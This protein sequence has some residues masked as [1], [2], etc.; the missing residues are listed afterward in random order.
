MRGQVFSR[1]WFTAALCHQHCSR[2]G[3]LLRASLPDPLS[4][5]TQSSVMP[6]ETKSWCR[7]PVIVPRDVFKREM[8]CEG[9]IQM[10]SYGK[11][12][13]DWA[14]TLTIGS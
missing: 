13:R 1:D 12:G 4:H 9:L 6:L 11:A 8:D 10:T 5:V 7:V 3:T 14:T 2:D